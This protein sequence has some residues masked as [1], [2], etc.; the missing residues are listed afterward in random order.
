MSVRARFARGVTILSCSAKRSTHSRYRQRW[1]PC[2]S[3][4]SASSFRENGR[5][6][7]SWRSLW[8]A[9]Q[10]EH[11]VSGKVPTR[12]LSAMSDQK[13]VDALMK[14]H[15][16]GQWTAEMFLMFVLN[17]TDV[18]PV[19]DLGLRDAVREVYKLDHRPT[20]TEVTLLAEPWRPWRSLATWYLWRRNERPA[21]AKTLS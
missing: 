16:I 5:R 4:G 2:S 17:R 7:H 20:A 8:T 13:V 10:A 15:G 14:V 19:D 9:I 12:R 1:Q 21:K 3:A 6:R 11:F 18:L